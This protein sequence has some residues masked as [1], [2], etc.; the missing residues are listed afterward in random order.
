[1]GT[2]GRWTLVTGLLDEDEV[3]DGEVVEDVD[4]GQWTM[5]QWTVDGGKAS[6]TSL[7][8]LG[9]YKRSS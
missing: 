2:L 3:D 8:C 7:Y 4:D 5:G 1:M 6:D 9:R